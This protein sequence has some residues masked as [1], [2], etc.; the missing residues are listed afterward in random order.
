[1]GKTRAIN[2]VIITGSTGMV[3]EGVLIQCLNSPEIDAVLVINRK[4]CG[5]NHAKL[6]EIIHQDFF[7]FSSIED[8]L[9]G[10]NACF[11]CLG[12]SSVGVDNDTYYRMTYTLTLHVAETLSKLN[13]KMTF[14]YVS[15]SGTDENGRLNWQKVKGKTENDLTKIPFEQVYHFRPGFIKP[16][17]GQKYAHNFYKYINWIFPIGRKFFA[18]GFCTMTEL[19]DAMINT[20]SHNSERRILEGKD[21]IALANEP[22]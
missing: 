4:P 5:Y 14:C 22:S 19:G 15:G 10:Y 2:N 18:N 21:I 16:I 11:F 9:K 17:K 6:K 8:Q 13:D 7:N 20:L 3:G 12:I 1:M